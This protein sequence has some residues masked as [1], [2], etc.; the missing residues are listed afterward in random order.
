VNNIEKS[1]YLQAGEVLDVLALEIVFT[2]NDALKVLSTVSGVKRVFGVSEPRRA[3][4]SRMVV[5]QTDVEVGADT[6]IEVF[7]TTWTVA[8]RYKIPFDLVKD[9]LF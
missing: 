8:E 4:I 5:N 1:V 9:L 6:L 7:Q 3:L 2:A